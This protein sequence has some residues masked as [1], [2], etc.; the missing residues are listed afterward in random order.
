MTLGKANPI[1][2][3]EPEELEEVDV[4]S[5]NQLTY[6]MVM[7]QIREHREPLKVSI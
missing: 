6:L 1:G 5:K 4:H 2:W 7:V 3:Q